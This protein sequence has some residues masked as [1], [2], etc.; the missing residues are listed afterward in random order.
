MISSFRLD[1]HGL[2]ANNRRRDSLIASLSDVIIALD[3]RADGVMFGEAVRARNQGRAV[4]VADGGREGN[5]KLIDLGIPQLSM[6]ELIEQVVPSLKN[7][8]LNL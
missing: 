3:V 5:R 6:D 1:D 7:R 4:F 8:R 2:G